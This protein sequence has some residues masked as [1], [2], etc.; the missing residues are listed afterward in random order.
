MDSFVSLLRADPKPFPPPMKICREMIEV[1]G[2]LDSPEFGYFLH[3]CCLSFKYLRL[4]AYPICL[5]LECMVTSGLKDVVKNLVRLPDRQQ[6]QQ[7]QQQQEQQQQQQ[8]QGGCGASPHPGAETAV[9][10]AAAAAAAAAAAGGQQGTDAATEPAAASAT[11]QQQ[12]QQQQAASLVPPTPPPAYREDQPAAAATA[13][14]AA[15]GETA[16]RLGPSGGSPL[17][18]INSSSSS[19]SSSRPVCLAIERVK[20]RFRL[21]LSDEDAEEMLVQV[22]MSSA[23]ALFPAVVDKLHEW[24]LYWK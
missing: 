20:E 21:D 11:Q 1:L 6:Q 18:S 10:P 7:Q 16:Y 2:S 24:S 19:S 4:H 13:T 8:Q 12:Q 9:A 22:I 3:L 15:A 5:L 23:R 14:A 17:R